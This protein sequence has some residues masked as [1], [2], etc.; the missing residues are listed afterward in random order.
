MNYCFILKYDLF[1]QIFGALLRGCTTRLSYLDLS[2]NYFATKKGKELPPSFKQYFTSSL[3]LRK[4]LL[5]QCKI[6]P[7]ALK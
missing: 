6:T 7:E 3:A 5:A 4:V 2:R 1:F